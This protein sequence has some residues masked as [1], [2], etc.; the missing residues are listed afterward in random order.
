MRET[1]Q[2][3]PDVRATVKDVRLAHIYIEKH[4][5]SSAVKWEKCVLCERA[6]TFQI[7]IRPF[8]VTDLK[9]WPVM[10]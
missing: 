2:K 5:K 7:Q 1:L 4:W 6:L 10:L 8:Y 9:K 3:T